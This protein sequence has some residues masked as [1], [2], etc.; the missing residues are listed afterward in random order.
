MLTLSIKTESKFRLKP[1]LIGSSFAC[2]FDSESE[3]MVP[4]VCLSKLKHK[5]L[6]KNV[7]RS[8]AA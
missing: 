4:T 5:L 1:K 2:W 3:C 8:L 7:L 6:I